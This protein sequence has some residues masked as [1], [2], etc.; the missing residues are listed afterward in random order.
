M[1]YNCGLWVNC[2]AS[3]SGVGPEDSRV[4]ATKENGHEAGRAGYTGTHGISWNP[5]D[6]LEPVSVSHCLGALTFDNA[7]DLQ[8]KLVPFATELCTLCLR[9]SFWGWVRRRHSCSGPRGC[10]TGCN[11]WAEEHKSGYYLTS[12]LQIACKFLLRTTLIWKQ[13]GKEILGSLVSFS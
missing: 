6:K 5:E 4:K 13:A 7:G 11:G 9:Q 10:P 3:W 2:A 12:V 8:E 1:G